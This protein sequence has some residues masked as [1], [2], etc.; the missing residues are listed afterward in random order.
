LV[1]EVLIGVG[2]E[3]VGRENRDEFDEEAGRSKDEC[4][5]VESADIR[6]L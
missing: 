5:Y 6:G 4:E 2:V 1:V 3:D